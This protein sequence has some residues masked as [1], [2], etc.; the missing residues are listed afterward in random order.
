MGGK[1]LEP[2]VSFTFYIHKAA[3]SVYDHPDLYTPVGCVKKSCHNISA[4]FVCIKIKGG[5][6]DFFF[7][8]LKHAQTIK[9]RVGI[10]V[11]IGNPFCP[12]CL[13]VKFSFTE[14]PLEAFGNFFM[15][16]IRYR[17][18]GDIDKNKE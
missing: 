8:L 3:E 5:Q 2:F 4:A 17:K 7:C 14:I 10:V 11:D 9:K 13:T 18:Q 6:D 1:S 15:P 16:D 12:C